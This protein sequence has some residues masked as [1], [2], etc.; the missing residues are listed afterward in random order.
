MEP[1]AFTVGRTTSYEETLGQP[2][3]KKLGL[4]LD[5][6]PPYHGGWVWRTK[7]EAQKFL[8]SGR[9]EE[10]SD[11]KDPATFS[12]YGLLLPNG[13]DTDVSKEPDPSDGVYRL[14]NDATYVKV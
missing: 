9:I 12:V 7:E 1:S 3:A 13:W 2:N 8:D 11:L 6:D 10:V 14:L 5:W 4:R